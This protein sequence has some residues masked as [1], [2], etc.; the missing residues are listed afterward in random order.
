MS[1]NFI[2]VT[3]AP[4]IPATLVRKK[5]LEL[6]DKFFS[7]EE[8]SGGDG[9]KD[10]YFYSEQYSDVVYDEKDREIT[11]DDLIKIFQTLIV[12]SKGNLEYVYLHAACT[13]S[14]MRQ[15]AFGGWVIFIRKDSVENFSTW[16]AI[17]R[18]KKR[19]RT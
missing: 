7:H 12:R 10:L 16:Q 11:Q 18:F 17:E 3:V 4:L 1:D 2:E 13:F 5:E 14:K 9:K 19:K 6:L 15:D 8:T